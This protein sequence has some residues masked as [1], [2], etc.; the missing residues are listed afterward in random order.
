MI[1]LRLQQSIYYNKL[2]ILG[3]NKINN[4]PYKEFKKVNKSII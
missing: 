2:P 1:K 4:Y 3:E